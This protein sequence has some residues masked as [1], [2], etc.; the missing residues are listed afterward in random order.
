MIPAYFKSSTRSY[1]RYLGFKA[2]LEERRVAFDENL[3]I[4][5]DYTVMEG[6]EAAARLVALANPPTAIVCGNDLLAMGA[7]AAVKEAG[8]AVGKDVSI[9]GFDD[10]EMSS[11]LDPPLTTV[12]IPAFEMGRKAAEVLID[13]IEN[14]VS[15][16]QHY[17]L[18]TDLI[19][20]GSTGPPVLKTIN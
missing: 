19:I 1:K 2:A 8:L 7:M 18:D 5:K 3:V 13:T 10:L 12:R 17:L 20:R 9:T 6:R 11:T 14:R 16:A 15:I 4:E